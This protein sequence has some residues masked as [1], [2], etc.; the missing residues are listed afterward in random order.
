MNIQI[1]GFIDTS[2]CDWDGYLSSVIFLPDCNLRCP[3]CQNGVLITDPHKIPTI[4]L[5]KIIR[6]LEN[7]R[8]W[9]DGVVITGGEPTIHQD[10]AELAREIKLLGFKVKIDTNGTRPDVIEE[11]VGKGLV[12]YI[13]MDIKA[14]LDQRYSIAAGKE[15]DLSL[16]SKSIQM[17]MNSSLP[18]EFR[19]TLVPGIVDGDAIESISS[20]IRRARKYVLQ[21]FVPDNSLDT[22]YRE[23]L[24]FS[25]GFVYELLDIARR[26][27]EDVSYRGK[28]GVGLS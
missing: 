4:G 18:Y 28:S 13:A 26:H 6:S 3:Y 8:N 19:T 15:V 21:R 12:D 24:P 16:I 25:D 20:S 10:L 1:K 11:I 27:V 5:D 14:P 7:R 22:T 9:I 2:L 23:R 17:I